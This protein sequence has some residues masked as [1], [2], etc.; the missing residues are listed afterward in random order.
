MRWLYV[1]ATIVAV[2]VSF[3][4]G[5]INRFILDVLLSI[6]KGLAG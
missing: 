4:H 3:S 1:V 2:Y 6:S 5:P